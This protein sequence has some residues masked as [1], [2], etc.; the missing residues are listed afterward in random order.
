MFDLQGALLGDQWSSNSSAYSAKVSRVGRPWRLSNFKFKPIDT[1]DAYGS[2]LPEELARDTQTTIAIHT[3]HDAHIAIAVGSVIQC[4]LELER[5]YETRYFVPKVDDFSKDW[6]RA[7]EVVRDHCECDA[8][9][10]PREFATGIILDYTQSFTLQ[11][12]QLSSIVERVFPVRSW[13]TANHHEAHAL[14][15]YYSSPFRSSLILSFDG[16]G[17]DGSWN[18]FVGQ[19]L[20]VYR[21]ARARGTPVTAYNRIASY[22][23]EVTGSE[24]SLKILCRSTESEEAEE[25][26]DLW[27]SYTIHW[28]FDRKLAFAGKLMGYSGIRTPSR[29]ASEVLRQ[30]FYFITQESD[31]RIPMA[32]LRMVCGSEEERQAVAAAAQDEFSK[33]VQPMVAEYLLQLKRQS[34][35]VEG[36]VLVGGGALNVLT[37]QV[38]RETLTSFT[39]GPDGRPRDVYVPPSPGDSGL[40]DEETLEDEVRDRGAQKLSELG[41]VEYLAELLAGGPS[42]QQDPLRKASVKPAAK[43]IVAV[44]RGRQEFGPRALGHRSLLG[45]PDEEMRDRMNRVKHRQWW[46]PAAPMIADEDLEYVF[47]HKFRS[48]YMEFAP[49]VREEVRERFP[50]LSHFDGTARHQSVGKEDE[51]W[52][53]ALLLA[54]GKRTGLAALINTSFNSRGKPICNTVT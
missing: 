38:I 11:G 3:G 21:I 37:N 19:G 9:P 22:L 2:F 40:F 32:L 18:V 31:Y 14:M 42:W 43:P 34:I 35:N 48:A 39:S 27:G 36:I 49:L 5:F 24:E 54:V 10:C 20:D 29:E 12:T 53:H 15:A 17:N 52:I 26:D 44:V 33:H 23:P 45:F 8:G 47:G 46:R 4:V 1:R 41:G 30:V 25:N 28:P 7:M 51:P 13:M 50:G 6:Q 16:G